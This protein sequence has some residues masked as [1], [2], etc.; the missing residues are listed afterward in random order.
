MSNESDIENLLSLHPYLIGEEFAG[1]KAQRQLTRG[2]NR[3]D[4]MFELP[5]GLCI[6]ELKKTPLSSEDARQLQRYCRAWSRNAKSLANYHYLIGKRPF[7][8]FEFRQAMTE[9]KYQIKVLYLNE[10]IPMTLSWDPEARR[11][12]SYDPDRRSLRCLRLRC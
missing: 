6:V 8:E 2:K 3:V 7:N 1:L 11:Y 4:L 12:I 5:Q 10:H 9:S